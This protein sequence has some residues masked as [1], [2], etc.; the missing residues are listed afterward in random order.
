MSQFILSDSITL[1]SVQSQNIIVCSRR[2][3]ISL[4]QPGSKREETE[5]VPV[6]YVRAYLQWPS[7]L[8][9]NPTSWI[10]CFSLSAMDQAFMIWAVRV[11]LISKLWYCPTYWM[12]LFLG[13]NFVIGDLVLLC[14]LF[15]VSLHNVFHVHNILPKLMSSQFLLTIRD[16]LNPKPPG[17]NVL[18]T[19]EWKLG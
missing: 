2:K 4:W 12:H 10:L 3:L 11:L 8:L 18:K 14:R 13:L 17:N 7:F 5:R 16:I 6:S 15:P 1:E 19:N 9:L